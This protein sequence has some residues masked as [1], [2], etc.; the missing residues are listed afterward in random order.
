MAFDPACSSAKVKFAAAN[1]CFGPIGSGGR[2]RGLS[3]VDRRVCRGK[4]L[5]SNLR[6]DDFGS[7]CRLIEMEPF[8]VDDAFFRWSHST[9]SQGAAF[10]LSRQT[11]ESTLEGLACC[12]ER[13]VSG[14]GP[15]ALICVGF[16]DSVRADLN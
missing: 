8:A 2:R 13:I 5:F 11:S 16:R 9:L 3:A 4:P 7:V 12:V 6:F 14:S 10:A 15:P 1:R